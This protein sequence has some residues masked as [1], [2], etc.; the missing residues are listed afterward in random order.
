[1]WKNIGL[2]KC[3]SFIESE[4]RPK[5]KESSVSAATRPAITISR[6]TGAGGHTVAS[7]LADYLQM[8][9]PAHDRWIVFDQNL[10]EKVLEDHRINKCFADFMEEGHKSMLIDSVEEW[11]GLHPSSWTFVQQTSAT[12]LQLAKMGNVILV[13]RGATVIT[14]KLKNVFHVRLVGSLEKRIEYGQQLYGLDRK[15]ALDFI[16]KRDEGRKRYLKDNFDADVDNP[17][18]Y[19]VIINTDLVQ[20]DEAARLI[21]DEVIKRFKLDSPVKAVR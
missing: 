9:V 18:L 21:G 4:L 2:E 15:A 13:G 20:Y 3:I 17:L 14:S 1:M 5:G 11:M 19:H 10:L 8:R 16:K 7:N 12:I 6:M